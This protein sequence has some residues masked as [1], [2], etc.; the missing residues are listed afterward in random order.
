MSKKHHV[1]FMAHRK[2]VEPLGAIVN[3]LGLV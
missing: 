1:E 2:V 3:A